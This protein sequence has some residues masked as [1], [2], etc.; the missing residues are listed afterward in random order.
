MP[1]L[2]L[3]S[4]LS[5]VVAVYFYV[6]A[7]ERTYINVLTPM[8]VIMIPTE[9]ILDLYHLAVFGPSASGFAYAMSYGSYAIYT[10]SLG[11][12]YTLFKAPRLRL[13]FD[14]PF[15]QGTKFAAYFVLLGA[16]I[17]YLPVII[18]FRHDLADP[19][20]IYTQTRVGYGQYFLLSI[21]LIYLALILLL[22]S[23]R[24][25]K[26]E[27]S[28]FL[29]VSLLLTWLQGSKGHMLGLFLILGLYFVYVRDY[30]IR[31]FKFLGVTLVTSAFGLGLFL[32]TTP[33]LLLNG[34]LRGLS[35]YS[36]YTR[37]AMLVIDSGI[38]PLYGKLNLEDQIYP[39]IPRLIDPNKPRD[40]GDFY[41]AKIFFP[42]EYAENVGAPAFG[43]G[44]W[45]ADFHVFA[46]PILMILGFFAGAFLKMCAQ[47]T[48]D[49]RTPGAF[50]LMLF[51]AGMPL[52]PIS[53]TFLLPE[54]LV[55]AVIANGLYAVH[56]RASK[57]NRPDPT[58]EPRC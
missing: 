8:Y 37:N 3:L 2:A 42:T 45:F 4:S 26:F 10:A 13:P 17:L 14:A 29:V 48:R 27:L 15:R 58:H 54:T 31:F 50:I 5:I 34:G 11:L 24:A 32:L 36:S 7:R 28:V 51:A 57:S 23:R 22:F 55:L 12:T 43:D 56:L 35:N 39:R 25:K 49:T 38:G 19:R 41:L 1:F 21:A 6:S 40:Y 16:A 18:K 20:Q 52:I 44:L 53:G 46:L 30:R 33:A 47:S 9:Y